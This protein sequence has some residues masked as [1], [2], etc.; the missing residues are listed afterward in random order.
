ME[1]R[2]LISFGKSSYIVSLPKTWIRQHK[3]SKGDLIYFDEVNNNLLLQ[4]RRN[5]DDDENKELILSIDKKGIRQIQREIISGYIRNYK[6]IILTGDELKNIVPEIQDIV[7]NLVALEVLEQTSTRIVAKDFLNMKDTDI[8]SLVKK[9]DVTVRSMLADCKISADEGL[10][11][12]IKHRDKD[13]NKLSYL[14]HRAIRYGIDNPG[15]A[16][17]KF[18]LTSNDFLSYWWVTYNIECIGDDTKRIARYM[19]QMEFTKPMKSHLQRILS[20]LEQDYVQIMN[21]LYKKDVAVAHAVHDRKLDSIK[22]CE[23]FYKTYN[24]ANF[25]GYLVSHLKSLATN[26]HNI[27]RS[28]YQY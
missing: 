22:D 11:K 14:L 19:D 9:M 18:G 7:Q 24:S 17:K 12:A 21:S 13:V 25:S 4:P 23:E 1:Y 10:A 15:N 5:E 28:I 20:K 8:R 3:L 16:M 27:G 26:I 2:K 6:T